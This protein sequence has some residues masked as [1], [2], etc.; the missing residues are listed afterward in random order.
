LDCV[1]DEGFAQ[2]ID[3]TVGVA[4]VIEWAARKKAKNTAVRVLQQLISG[5]VGSA[6]D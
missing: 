3:V 1:P 5:E 4:L 6:K 2:Q